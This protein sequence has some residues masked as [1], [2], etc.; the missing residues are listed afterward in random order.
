MKNDCYCIEEE[1]RKKKT[2]PK[3]WT[4]VVAVTGL[5]ERP[6]GCRTCPADVSC[7]GDLSTRPAAR[8]L[9]FPSS[10]PASQPA[11]PPPR[12][13]YLYRAAHA[14]SR[15]FA[16]ALQPVLGLLNSPISLSQGTLPAC[17]RWL[18]CNDTTS[19]VQKQRALVV[20]TSR[21]C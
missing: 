14:H 19:E 16:A 8:A 20:M 5:T 11:T 18:Y 13:W 21:P 3:I 12:R 10:I 1:E 15:T 4:T 9:P 7:L 2:D 6:G 17:S